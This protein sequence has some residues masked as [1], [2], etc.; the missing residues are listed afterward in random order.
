VRPFNS[1]EEAQN[2]YDQT[3]N[4][5]TPSGLITPLNVALLHNSDV[6]ETTGDAKNMDQPVTPAPLRGQTGTPYSPGSG[7]QNNAPG[8]GSNTA[9]QTHWY[10]GPLNFITTLG[11][12]IK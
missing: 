8:F 3:V 9:S 11:G 1:K 12:L 5:G 4:A 6:V 7:T 10:T 2:Y